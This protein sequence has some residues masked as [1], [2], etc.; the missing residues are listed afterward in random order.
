[1]IFRRIPEIVNTQKTTRIVRGNSVL[2]SQQKCRSNHFSTSLTENF[3]ST[4]YQRWTDILRIL[5]RGFQSKHL[6]NRP[7]DLSPPPKKKKKQKKKKKNKKKT[8]KTKNKTKKPHLHTYNSKQTTKDDITTTKARPPHA[9]FY[10]RLW[11][12]FPMSRER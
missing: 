10:A 6:Q 12:Q 4:T 3:D 2:I 1:M 11:T 5:Q 8:K 7:W 9:V